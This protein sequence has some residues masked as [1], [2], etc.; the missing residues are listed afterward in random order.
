[1]SFKVNRLS[2]FF[3]VCL[4]GSIHSARIKR[5]DGDES[6]APSEPATSESPQPGSSS[7][8]RSPL[9]VSSIFENLGQI[10]PGNNNSPNWIQDASAWFNNWPNWFGGQ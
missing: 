9:D 10:F 3:F 4:I 5:D 1:M 7:S 6:T 2:A 8:T